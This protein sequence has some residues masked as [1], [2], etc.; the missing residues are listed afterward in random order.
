MGL[1]IGDPVK[2]A[3]SAGDYRPCKHYNVGRKGLKT[4]SQVQFLLGVWLHFFSNVQMMGVG[5]KFSP[6]A[7]RQHWQLKG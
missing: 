7:V 5:T 4:L 1:I 6:S 3:F 2:R